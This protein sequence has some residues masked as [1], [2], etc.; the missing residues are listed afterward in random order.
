MQSLWWWLELIWNIVYSQTCRSLTA[1]GNESGL[2][3]SSMF[4][5]NYAPPVFPIWVKIV[6]NLWQVDKVHT[7]A[8]GGS[9]L[10]GNSSQDVFSFI[11]NW[12][13][14]KWGTGDKAIRELGHPQWWLIAPKTSFPLVCRGRLR[15]NLFTSPS[16]S[17]S[18]LFIF[19]NRQE[20]Q[21][22]RYKPGK[23]CKAADSD[24]LTHFRYT[25]LNIKRHLLH[26]SPLHLQHWKCRPYFFIY[27]NKKLVL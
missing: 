17:S 12:N 5:C 22:L 27:N 4:G 15:R 18:L 26:T 10:Y 13:S 11:V 7:H 9:H 6:V 24:P 16:P 21:G 14:F 23:Q 19:R 8:F 2:V 25:L 1:A 20:G 3:L